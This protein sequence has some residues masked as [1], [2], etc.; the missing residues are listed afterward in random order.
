MKEG[1]TPCTVQKSK[2]IR[3]KNVMFIKSKTTSVYIEKKENT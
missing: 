2:R 1:L 3:I